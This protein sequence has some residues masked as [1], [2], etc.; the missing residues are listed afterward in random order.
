MLDTPHNYWEFIFLYIHLEPLRII[1]D[2][3]ITSNAPID[4]VNMELSM[5]HIH[6][7]KKLVLHVLF[8]VSV[9]NC[10]AEKIL[11]I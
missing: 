5:E 2:D 11:M 10:Q 8:D 9:N 7:P 1:E 3:R 6:P 4:Q